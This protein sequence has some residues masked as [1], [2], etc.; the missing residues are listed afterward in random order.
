[1]MLNGQLATLNKCLKNIIKDLPV[2]PVRFITVQLSVSTGCTK[3]STLAML[4]GMHY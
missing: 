1:M 4:C 2:H 3:D